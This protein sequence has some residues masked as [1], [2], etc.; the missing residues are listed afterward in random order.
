MKYY[1]GL[2]DDEYKITYKHTKQPAPYNC[3]HKSWSYLAALAIQ[4]ALEPDLKTNLA[5]DRINI[6]QG[7]TIYLKGDERL[8]DYFLCADVLEDL[9]WD[10][11]R[12]DW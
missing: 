9:P 4:K 8:E 2:H 1:R 11:T 12:I 6:A 5:L 3:L 10:A 7:T